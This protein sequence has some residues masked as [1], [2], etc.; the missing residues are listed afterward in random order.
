MKTT[1][2]GR[3]IDQTLQL[4]HVPDLASGGENEIQLEVTFDGYWTGYGKEAV[5]RRDKKRI[6]RVVMVDGVCLVPWEVM[7]EPG[8]VFVSIRGT[9]G[10]N[11]RP[12][13]EATL[14][15]EQGPVAEGSYPAP[16]PDV[17]KQLLSAQGANA[18]AI[19]A[20]RARIDNQLA[21][22]TVDGELID[23]RVGA[24]GSTYAT[25]G[26]AVRSQF[27][28]MGARTTGMLLHSK[29]TID[30][31]LMPVYSAAGFMNESGAIV[32][33]S[34]HTCVAFNMAG[35]KSVAFESK[36]TFTA[37]AFVVKKGG[38]VYHVGKVVYG[39]TS[40]SY[41]FPETLSSDHIGYFN[42]F[43]SK[44][45][46]LD[47]FTRVT[48]GFDSAHNK[49]T[50]SKSWAAIGDSI[51]WL[52]DNGGGN[53][54]ERGYQSRLQDRIT[55]GGVTNCGVNGG[56]MKGYDVSSIPAADIYTIALGINDWGETNLTPVGTLAD[57]KAN[58]DGSASDNYAECLR[59]MVNRIRELN[60]A[61]FIILITPRRAYGFEGYL[62]ASSVQPNSAGVYLHE[63]AD[64]IN[65]V[66]R[67]EG[68]P[69]A[70]LYYNS[71]MHDG[72]LAAYSYDV[73]LHPNDAGMQII[74]NV[75]YAPMAAYIH[76]GE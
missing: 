7:A 62:P 21:A 66:A 26:A 8:D 11:I 71:G 16:L 48:L 72:N 73:A 20:E 2:T 25:A 39:E 65:D 54:P 50:T 41:T 12:T 35:V 18:Q 58:A 31:S 17:Y 1:I 28:M 44:S 38:E 15:F 52:N 13:N 24:D 59:R 60:S 70:D 49:I 42:Y 69:V 56:T 14:R 4:T 37:C 68:F 76:G 34:G 51:T 22:G 53:R 33:H 30:L 36:T 47:C 6:Y 27:G 55:F 46:A 75:L 29:E 45:G 67:F 63:Y 61:A 9:S 74:A 40:F 43:G 23:I 10:S 32:D 64:L 57:Y 3:C 19:A 5:F